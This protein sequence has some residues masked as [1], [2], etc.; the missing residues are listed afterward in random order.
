MP[1]QS[2][3]LQE[4]RD[5]A[6]RLIERAR[7]LPADPALLD[8]APAPDAWSVAR[9]LEHLV[10][11]SECYLAVMRQAVE[12]SPR[13]PAGDLRWR[14]RVGGRLL[15]WSLRSSRPLPAPRGFRPGPGPRPEVREAFTAEMRELCAL[16]E[17]SAD[18][19]WNDVRFGSPVLA[20]L[21]LNLG[22]GFE[23]LLTHAERHFR[24]IDRVLTLVGPPVE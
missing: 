13:R 5:R 15:V 22:D 14:P 24:Q 4:W 21:R 1:A 6:G 10:L 12:R 2:A 19:P 16:L 3:Y 20:A 18:L 23:I 8:R 11:S 17:R 7:A 9:V